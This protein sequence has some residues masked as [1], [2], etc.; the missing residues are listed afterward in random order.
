MPSTAGPPRPDRASAARADAISEDAEADSARD[1]PGLR[2]EL[3]GRGLVARVATPGELA[4]GNARRGEAPG[5]EQRI[6]KPTLLVRLLGR[7]RQVVRVDGTR[8]LD[9]RPRGTRVRGGPVEAGEREIRILLDSH[10][11]SRSCC[12]CRS[13]DT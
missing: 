3:V 13:D 10:V 12:E 5:R 8:C 2:A 7:D 11:D 9:G 4:P 1:E 6:G